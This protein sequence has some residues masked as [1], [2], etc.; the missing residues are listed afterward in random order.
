MTALVRTRALYAELAQA[1]GV[2]ALPPDANGGIELQVGA[3]TTVI[4]YAEGDRTL[5]VV[6]PL[7]AL[8]REPD[9]GVMAWLLRRNLFDSELLPFCIAADA[10]ANLILW[11][12]VPVEGQTGASL[13][14]LIDALGREAARI[15][16]EVAVDETPG[17]RP[18]L[19]V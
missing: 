7:A 8:P 15:R 18:P 12:R 4:L 3:D 9:Y 6:V 19:G 2:A 13:A 16:A 5:L 10:H 11:G 17:A 1:L 14:G